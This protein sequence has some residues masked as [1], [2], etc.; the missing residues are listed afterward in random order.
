MSSLIPGVETT[1]YA[2]AELLAAGGAGRG[3]VAV[4][5]DEDLGAGAQRAVR[6]R[7][8]VA[9]DHVGLEPGL[10]QRVG[11]AVDRDQHGLEVADV[12]ADDPQVALV[13]GPARDD[14]RVPVAEARLERREVDALREQAPL[15]AQ[16][17]HRVLG[18]RLERLGH[19]ALLRDQRAVE[20]ACLQH[21]P[22]REARAVAEDA[23]AAHGEL[24]AVATPVE[25]LGAGRVDQPDAAADER[26]RAGVR[27]AAASATRRTLTTTRTPDSTSSSAETRSRSA[28]SMIAMSS[29]E[30]RR[31]RCFVRRSSRAG[32][33]NSTGSAHLLLG[34]DREELLAAEHPLELVAPLVVLEPLDASCASGRRG[35]SRRGS[36]G[37]RGSRSA[38]GA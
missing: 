7:V 17:A 33:V 20:L 32:P 38:G 26:E 36:G 35:P 22:R 3:A 15:V 24:L 28:W 2:N 29:S 37:R 31:T 14:E 30:S 34:Q 1:W 13:P 25:Q 6:D 10:E 16:V 9:D 23:A 5:V 19:A 27:E 12:R 11:A 18:E 8:H 4:R 21:A